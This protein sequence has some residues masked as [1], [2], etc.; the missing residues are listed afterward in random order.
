MPIH[1]TTILQHPPSHESSTPASIF[2]RATSFVHIAKLI[3][4]SEASSL[5]AKARAERANKMKQ[6][7]LSAECRSQPH[8][9]RHDAALPQVQ[10]DVQAELKTMRAQMQ[11]EF[12]ELSSRCGDGSSAFASVSPTVCSGFRAAIQLRRSS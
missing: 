10:T 9:A 2:R 5:I 3:I 11:R 12:D 4:L 1:S 6:V 8:P 7:Q